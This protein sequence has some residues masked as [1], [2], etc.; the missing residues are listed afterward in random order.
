MKMLVVV[1]S[2][3]FCFN[4]FATGDSN[5]SN[6][7]YSKKEIKEASEA[8]INSATLSKEEMLKAVDQLIK[9]GKITKEEG[10]QTKKAI[11]QMNEK[12]MAGLKAAIHA[13]MGNAIDQMKMPKT[14]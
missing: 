7:D 13:L 14:E 9:E 1:M 6:G 4:S 10:E 8:M 3:A 12:D 11:K 2:L 5:S